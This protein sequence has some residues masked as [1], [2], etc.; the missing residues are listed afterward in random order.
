M[1]SC[2][3][4]LLWVVAAGWLAAPAVT[5]GIVAA[6]SPASTAFVNIRRFTAFATDSLAFWRVADPVSPKG[7]KNIFLHHGSHC[8]M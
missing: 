4:A 1:R 6:P 7:S 8:A 2:F 3:A 5:C